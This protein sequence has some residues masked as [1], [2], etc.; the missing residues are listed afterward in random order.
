MSG[1]DDLRTA[2]AE[3][4]FKDRWR[5]DAMHVM[6]V[7]GDPVR[8]LAIL[9]LIGDVREGVLI[10]RHGFEMWRVR[11]AI[12][13]VTPNPLVPAYVVVPRREATDV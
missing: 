7:L 12:S 3:A 4:E 6:A 9:N 2:I 11:P 8:R 10:E 1:A 13:G 5:E